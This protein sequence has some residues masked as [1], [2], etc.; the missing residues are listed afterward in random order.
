MQRVPS[1]SALIVYTVCVI[2]F[3]VSYPHPPNLICSVSMPVENEVSVRQSGQTHFGFP[4]KLFGIR[5]KHL[6]FGIRVFL[7]GI[8]DKL[9]RFSAF[10]VL[11]FRDSAIRDVTGATSE[12]NRWAWHFTGS[13]LCCCA[14]FLWLHCDRTSTKTYAYRVK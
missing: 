7:F 3:A 12:A 6:P 8:P 10:R 11:A 14:Y 5:D 1:A 2:G 4:D 13:T 9:T